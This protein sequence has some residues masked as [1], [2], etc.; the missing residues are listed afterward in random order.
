MKRWGIIQAR[1]NPK[2]INRYIN[3]A[4]SLMVV[5]HTG[6][7]RLQTPSQNSATSNLSP[8]NSCPKWIIKLKKTQNKYGGYK[9]FA[10]KLLIIYFWIIFKFRESCV[11]MLHFWKSYDMSK[12]YTTINL[13]VQNMTMKKSDIVTFG[14]KSLFDLGSNFVWSTWSL[15]CDIFFSRPT[16]I[17]G[18]WASHW[19]N[20]GGTRRRRDEE[21]PLASS[22]GQG[23]LAA[24][25]WQTEALLH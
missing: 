11:C 8:I 6:F 22:P 12:K 23:Q 13:N 5:I 19:L 15:D 21:G 4:V 9:G 16:P 18:P 7:S 2:S 17:G 14:V 24:L 1:G 20:K 10:L 25:L 3:Y